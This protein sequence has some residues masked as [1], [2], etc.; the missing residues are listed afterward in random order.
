MCDHPND[1]G[2]R[3]CEVCGHV[4]DAPAD[5]E[6]VVATADVVSAGKVERA[7]PRPRKGRRRR[8]LLV[9]SLLCLCLVL[10]AV[11]WTSVQQH[12]QQDV[13]T[14]LRES[15]RVIRQSRG[16]LEALISA[17][18]KGKD[19]PR[20]SARIVSRVLAGRRK[21][22]T[23]VGAWDPPAA[24]KRARATLELALRRSIVSDGYYLVWLRD[25]AARHDR[26]AAD[27][28]LNARRS[29]D[30]ATAAKRRFMVLYNRLRKSI[31]L[32]PVFPAVLF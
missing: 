31:G 11:W 12:R 20:R 28:R 23:A 21:L 1:L 32:L 24:A 19:S 27:A 4:S 17:L 14:F 18:S 25:L 3:T 15:H 13:P 10:S 7:Y 22:L 9:A 26:A 6:R 29:D 8:V 30:K 2:S 5:E 16:E